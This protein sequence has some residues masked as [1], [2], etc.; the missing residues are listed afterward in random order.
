[1]RSGVTR[2]G[3]GGRRG[4]LVAA[5]A[6][7][8][9][10][11]AVAVPIILDA[12]PWPGTFRDALA[13]RGSRETGAR[14]LVA[15]TYLGYRA[16][17]TLMETVVL[18][19]AV[20]AVVMF[21]PHAASSGASA[22]A[23]TVLGA[24]SGATRGA[25]R[26]DLIRFMAGKLSPLVLVFGCYVILYGDSSPGG[27]FQ[28]GVVLASGLIFLFLGRGRR[29]SASA[30]A[31]RSALPLSEALAFAVALLVFSAGMAAGVGFSGNFVPHDWLLPRSSFVVVL[32]VA[33]GLK[34]GAGTALMCVV[35]LEEV[36][37]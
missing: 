1:M 11:A 3:G 2:S 37:S 17:D 32:N 31:L 27:G 18:L 36:V 4:D 35:M 25:E 30:A 14:N 7:A 29:A 28:G 33:I 13:D 19:V 5:I 10:C 8:L 20:A 21:A 16:Y 6:A 26:F 9:L 23:P 15:A 12:T 34:V 24:S 22:S